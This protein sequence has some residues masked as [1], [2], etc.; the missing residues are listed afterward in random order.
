MTPHR[1]PLRDREEAGRLLADELQPWRQQKD[2]IV[3][4]L[5]RGGVPVAAVIAR[6]LQARLDLMLVRKLGMPGYEEL[7]MGAIASGGV[8]VRNDHV[9]AL[10]PHPEAAIAAAVA[11]ESLE[12]ERRSHAYRGQRPWPDLQGQKVIL[13]DD[14]LATGATLRA[15][16]VAVRRQRPAQLIAAVPVGAADSVA[17]IRPLV[18]RLICPHEPEP[19]TAIGEWYVQFDQVTDEEVRDLLAEAWRREDQGYCA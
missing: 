2:V 11:R 14:G 12:L 13:V 17:R 6:A 5:P 7:A 19:F 4:A 18:D 3:L 1:L 10:L 15:A 8:E 9:L 16:I